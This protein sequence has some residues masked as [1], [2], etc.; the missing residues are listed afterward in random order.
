LS[1]RSAAPFALDAET[2]SVEPREVEILAPVLLEDAEA[3]RRTA[4]G[5]APRKAAEPRAAMI[6]PVVCGVAGM[7][8]RGGMSGSEGDVSRGY[9]IHSIRL[10]S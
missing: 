7:R 3:L 2:R 4:A 10:I 8:R 6:L 5:M 1:R 9:F